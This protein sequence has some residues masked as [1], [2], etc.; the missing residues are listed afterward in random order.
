MPNHVREHLSRVLW[1]TLER[2][3]L[4]E[5]VFDT[6]IIVEVQGHIPGTV[7]VKMIHKDDLMKWVEEKQYNRPPRYFTIKVSESR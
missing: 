4:N 6:E 5:Y 7:I 3:K 1:G 2:A